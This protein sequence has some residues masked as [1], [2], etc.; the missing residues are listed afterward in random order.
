MWDEFDAIFSLRTCECER[1]QKHLEHA[2]NLK[3]FQFLNGLNESYSA[4]RSNLLMREKLPN[5]NHAYVVLIQKE[6]QR[7]IDERSMA[8]AAAQYKPPRRIPLREFCKGRC[9]DVTRC[10]KKLG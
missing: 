7:G 9:H 6:H 1:F 10:F 2:S 8:N 3:L 4:V 5:L